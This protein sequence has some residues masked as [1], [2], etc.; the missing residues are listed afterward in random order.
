[1]LLFLHITWLAGRSG[2]LE[3]PTSAIVFVVFIIRRMTASSFL[4]DPDI[5]FDNLANRSLFLEELPAAN[6]SNFHLM[7]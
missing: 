7:E 1:M 2:L 6:A 5:V 4:Y 3:A